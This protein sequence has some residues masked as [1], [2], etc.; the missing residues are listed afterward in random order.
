MKKYIT[1]L[2]LVTA[3]SG[4]DDATKVIDQAQESAN[5]AVDSL[6]E[7]M[8]S[9]DLSK[10]NLDDL[11]EAAASAKELA[12]SVDEALNVDFNDSEALAEVKDHIANAYS[13]L[14]DASSESTAEKLL[15]KVLATISNEEAQ[16]LIE[17]GIDKAKEAKECVM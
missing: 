14:V 16:S 2:M 11:G 13:C 4:C 10:L 15:N 8:D 3:L 9:V 1:A 6:Q 17:K 5:K 7:K 12:S